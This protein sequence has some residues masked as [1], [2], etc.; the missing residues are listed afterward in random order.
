MVD[1][2]YMLRVPSS[3]AIPLLLTYEHPHFPLR[4]CAHWSARHALSL[5]SYLCVIML[6]HN[7]SQGR[8]IAK[9]EDRY[10]SA[11]KKVTASR[12]PSSSVWTLTI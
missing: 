1:A 6:H 11:Y 8:V 3:Y 10:L 5:I 4:I 2:S 7:I 9:L 12:G